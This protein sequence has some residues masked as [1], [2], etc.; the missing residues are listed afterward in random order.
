MNEQVRTKRF[1]T[2]KLRDGYD[3]GE[4]DQFIDELELSVRSL[5][6]QKAVL[7]QANLILRSEL[8]TANARMLAA[9]EEL[10]RL[11]D[12]EP[13]VEPIDEAP[14]AAV[15]ASRSATRLL[16]MAARE[17]EALVAEAREEAERLVGRAQVE[18][19]Q[20]T[21]ASMIEAQER[22]EALQARLGEVDA[23]VNRL[24]ELGHSSRDRAR[25]LLHQPAGGP[26]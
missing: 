25:R 21:W 7:E 10:G 15:T 13:T 18:A 1:A 4:V 22:E 2:V 17:A 11:S 5:E 19:E 9:E 3:M 24:V 8:A 26:G 6:S 16:E 23:E 14:D 20:L 12:A